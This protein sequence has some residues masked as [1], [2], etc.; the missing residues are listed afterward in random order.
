MM[1][2]RYRALVPVVL[3]ALLTACGTTPLSTHYLLTAS[4]DG[5]PA[6]QS[7]AIGVGPV[8]IPE[9]LNR[10]TL[11]YRDV[12]NELKIAR[13]A[14]WAEP[15]EDGISRVL[16]LNLAGLLDTQNVRAFPWHPKRAPD[17]GI[18]VRVLR[19]DAQNDE[20]ILLA[21]WVVF[22]PGQDD[23]LQR[24]ISQHAL[25]LDPHRPVAP[26][27]PAAHS[28]LLYRMSGEIAAAVSAAEGRN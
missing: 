19:M 8:E 18:K 9:Y 21:E 13:Q 3:A 2:Q 14:R 28:T 20:A 10:Y 12:E 25:P 6:A 1:L 7:P 17:Y 24:G 16:I 22:R 15:L 27:L 5:T 26:Q 4:M 23:E 11:V